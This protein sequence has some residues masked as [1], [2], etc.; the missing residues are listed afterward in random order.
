MIVDPNIFSWND[1]ITKYLV[2]MLLVGVVA[3]IILIA[4][5]AGVMRMIKYR[6]FPH[7]KRD[8]SNNDL[9]IDDD[10]QREKQRI[11]RM[12]LNELKS[13]TLV[14]KDVSK[15]YGSLCAVNKTSI[16]IKR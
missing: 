15:F 10:V 9:V 12:G 16:A 5:E 4:I 11:D 8:Y 13:E 14:M 1:G 7:L 2:A 3:Y 6:I